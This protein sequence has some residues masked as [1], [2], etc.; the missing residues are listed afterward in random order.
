MFIP[1][2]LSFLKSE[3]KF[4]Y[5]R[6]SD[7]WYHF[8][9]QYSDMQQLRI[10]TTHNSLVHLSWHPALVRMLALPATGCRIM[11]NLSWG[12]RCFKNKNVASLTGVH[13][14]LP[15]RFLRPVWPHRTVRRWDP[16]S[17]CQLMMM[18]LWSVLPPTSWESLCGSSIIVSVGE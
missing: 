7:Y 2:F 10:S 14:L 3:K 4:C 1:L 11:W 18:S 17:S 8:G 5:F 13:T 12:R 6:F 16:T 15:M 9:E